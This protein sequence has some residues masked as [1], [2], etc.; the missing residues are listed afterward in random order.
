MVLRG[1]E[2]TIY[3]K[4]GKNHTLGGYLPAFLD[5]LF[6]PGGIDEEDIHMTDK[7]KPIENCN[8]LPNRE[9]MADHQVGWALAQ[10]CKLQQTCQGDAHLLTVGENNTVFPALPVTCPRQAQVRTANYLQQPAGS[11]T[12]PTRNSIIYQISAEGL[13]HAKVV[14]F[15]TLTSAQPDL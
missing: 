12:K 8:F 1:K 6:L 4:G 15:R 13:R 5:E 14:G 11:A 7:F 10:I 2:A 9:D 3:H